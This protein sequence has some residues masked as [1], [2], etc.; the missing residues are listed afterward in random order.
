MNIFTERKEYQQNSS[1]AIKKQLIY[2]RST[3]L[4]LFLILNFIGYKGQ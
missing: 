2:Q 4:A 1:F 3:I